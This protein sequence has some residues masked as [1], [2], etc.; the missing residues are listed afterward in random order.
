MSCGLMPLPAW[1]N[2]AGSRFQQACPSLGSTKGA[3]VFATLP[4][5]A[6]SI[7]NDPVMNPGLAP[8]RH[9][10][11]TWTVSRAHAKVSYN[12]FWKSRNHKHQEAQA[13]APCRC[14][15]EEPSDWLGHDVD[16][17]FARL[18]QISLEMVLKWVTIAAE[19]LRSFPADLGAA[20]FGRR[21][22]ALHVG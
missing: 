7:A 5:E 14:V 20:M 15:Y 19:D 21:D 6:G 13:V 18:E 16:M 8:A 4:L 2:V 9:A 12:L 17:P 11:G 1:A 3:A 22:C 10:A